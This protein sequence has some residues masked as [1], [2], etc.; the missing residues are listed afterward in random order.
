VLLLWLPMA[1]LADQWKPYDVDVKQEAFAESMGEPDHLLPT[2]FML[3]RKRNILIHSSVFPSFL[4]SNMVEVSLSSNNTHTVIE[5][6][7]QAKGEK[8]WTK[9]G[10]AT[11][12]LEIAEA[13]H[14]TWVNAL[15][16]TRHSRSAF[17]GLDGATFQFGAFV[18]GLGW[19]SGQTWSP[20]TDAP[21]RHMI[22][23]SKALH[24]F[25]QGKVSREDVQVTTKRESE[26]IMN[27]LADN[28][29]TRH[30][31]VERLPLLEQLDC[32]GEGSI[33]T[34][35]LRC[36]LAAAER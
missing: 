4:P 12:P 14:R 16:E 25:T 19:L 21:P 13:L 6:F 34:Q 31:T 22:V 35:L 24:D 23:I 29:I 10:A 27:Y 17:R 5:A 11:L 15:F 7:T 1:C 30:T 33:A 2:S 9:L 36:I 28:A 8:S 26:W 32:Q 18:R 20:D 3:P